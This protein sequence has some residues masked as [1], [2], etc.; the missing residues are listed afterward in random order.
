MPSVGSEWYTAEVVDV[1]VADKETVE[2]AV[3]V[4]LNSTPA[5]VGMISARSKKDISYVQ[6]P[7]E[8]FNR[9]PMPL[10]SGMKPSAFRALAKVYDKWKSEKR[11]RLPEAHNC[12]VQLAIDKAV[13]KHTG[14]D[15]KLCRQA[16]RLLVHE[17]MVTGQ[18]YQPQQ[19]ESDKELF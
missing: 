16:R 13:C 17:P 14:F 2:K 5:K 3:C 10:L 15:E 18:R 9:I 11:Q 7:T 1:T 6:F 19:E 4:I 12:S 8:N